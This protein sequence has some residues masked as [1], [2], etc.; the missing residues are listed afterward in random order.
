[1]AN[2]WLE[3]VLANQAFWHVSSLQAPSGP[4]GPVPVSIRV[5]SAPRDP[6]WLAENERPTVQQLFAPRVTPLAL[7]IAVPAERHGE[8]S[9]D[10][11]ERFKDR[12]QLPGLVVEVGSSDAPVTSGIRI[13]DGQ[14]EH[15]GG[16]GAALAAWVAQVIASRGI[17]IK[18]ANT[19]KA[20]N[21]GTVNDLLHAWSRSLLS[22]DLIVNDI[23]AV[24][25][26]GKDGPLSLVEIKRSAYLPWQPYHADA[27]NY[28]LLRA[29]SMGAKAGVLDITLHYDPK[30]ERPPYE[31]TPHFVVGTPLSLPPRMIGFAMTPLREDTQEDA[32]TMAARFVESWTRDT[33]WS[34]R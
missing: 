9:L 10:V 15:S 22:S 13:L 32:A 27:S 21:L 16:D 34:V 26:T 30:R 28:A 29:L 24:C 17:T 3:G 11:V 20:L 18:Q 31:V 7:I 6:F 14:A 25:F 5:V 19:H 33:Y 1:V 23:D 2:S 12:L 8:P 4:F